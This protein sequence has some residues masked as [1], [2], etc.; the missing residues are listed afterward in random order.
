MPV[1]G[2]SSPFSRFGPRDLGQQ[3]F[4]SPEG[5]PWPGQ[6]GFSRRARPG[7]VDQGGVRPTPAFGCLAIVPTRLPSRLRTISSPSDHAP[8]Q[9]WLPC[10]VPHRM[11]PRVS[12]WKCREREPHATAQSGYYLRTRD[13]TVHTETPSVH[14]NSPTF[15]KS[16]I[17]TPLP[18]PCPDATELQRVCQRRAVHEALHTT[19]C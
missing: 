14:T 3:T 1:L 7:G 9:I 6:A 12:K 2:L 19:S 13:G 11:T 16:L 15:E 18:A 4:L 5:D 17:W 8:L 10:R